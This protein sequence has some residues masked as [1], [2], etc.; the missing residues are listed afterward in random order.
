MLKWGSKNGVRSELTF[1]GWRW[2]NIEKTYSSFFHFLKLVDY[3]LV[4]LTILQYVLVLLFQ[5]FRDIWLNLTDTHPDANLSWFS[6][7]LSVWFQI[8]IGFRFCFFGQAHWLSSKVLLSN[9][10]SLFPKIRSK[11]WSSTRFF[12]LRPDSK[13]LNESF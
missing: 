10:K 7:T 11:T 8:S 5:T 13:Q 9:P 1:A 12:Y 4:N 6:T 2:A 3:R